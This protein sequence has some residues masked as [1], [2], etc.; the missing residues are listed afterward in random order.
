MASLRTQDLSGRT[1]GNLT[2]LRRDSL[3][4]RRAGRVWVCKCACGNEVSVET[5]RLTSAGKV[6]CGCLKGQNISDSKC[7]DLTGQRFSRLV[8][9]RKEPRTPESTDS[10]WICKC[11]CGTEKVILAGSLKRGTTKSCGCLFRE[12]G[13]WMGPA[14][15]VGKAHSNFRGVG[16]LP[17]EYYHQLERGALSR[18]LEWA[19]SMDYLWKLF[20]RQGGKCRFTGTQLEFGNTRY[21]PGNCAS[22]DRIDSSLGYL[23]GNVQWVHRKINFLKG[24]LSDGEFIELCSLVHHHNLPTS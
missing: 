9:L 17:L 18:D 21:L 15:G 12:H 16:D 10:R 23:E 4:R 1:F 11:D 5:S 7:H 19:V 8:A 14:L 22:L 20:L 6:H 24:K 3:P 13:V 2:V